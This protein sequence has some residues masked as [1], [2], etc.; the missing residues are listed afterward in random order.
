MLVPT[1]FTI[2]EHSHV[3]SQGRRNSS[4]IVHSG[5]ELGVQ[6]EQ[7]VYIIHLLSDLHYVNIGSN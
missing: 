7:E 2:C 6:A 5:V 4:L 3:T 1:G